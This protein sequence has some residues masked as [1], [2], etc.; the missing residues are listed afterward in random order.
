MYKVIANKEKNR[1]YITLGVVETGEGEKFVND[2]RVETAKLG[3]TFTCVS[4]I[5][6]FS[7]KDPTEAVWAEKA[8]KALAEAGMVRAVRVTG[9]EVE[10][11]ET[12]E[13]YGYTVGLAKTI[14]DADQILDAY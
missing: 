6:N 14:E 11:K 10:Y 9:S 13:E 12:K 5:T 1:I 7:F 4:D 8:L 3:E 2:I